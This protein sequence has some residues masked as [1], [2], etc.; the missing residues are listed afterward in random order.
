MELFLRIFAI[1]G[2]GGVLFAL[3]YVTI[4]VG[5]LVHGMIIIMAGPVIDAFLRKRGIQVYQPG[6]AR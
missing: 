2:A 3:T 6:S 4:L 1:I 5:I